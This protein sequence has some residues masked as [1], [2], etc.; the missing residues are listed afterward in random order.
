MDFHTTFTS[1]GDVSDSFHPIP[2]APPTVILHSI[3][4]STY[5]CPFDPIEGDYAGPDRMYAYLVFNDGYIEF[6]EYGQNNNEYYNDCHRDYGK[7]LS[8]SIS[9]YPI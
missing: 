5:G 4:L 9:M 6:Q 1:W 3:D 8:S 7:T 2:D